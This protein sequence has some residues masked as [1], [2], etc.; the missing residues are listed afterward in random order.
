M[1]EAYLRRTIERTSELSLTGIDP[2]S[3]SESKAQL[4]LSSVYT[5]LLTLTPESHQRLN[6]GEKLGEET[7]R[8]SAL[9]QL[10]R[11]R[12]LVLL[13]DPGSGK[14]TF[15]NFVALCMAGE[16]LGHDEVNLALLTTPLPQKERSAPVPT[17]GSWPAFARAGDFARL[18]GSGIARSGGKSHCQT[19]LGLYC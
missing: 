2:K 8:L 1:R 11:H 9:E 19:S 13:G 10:N 6:R 7:R 18:R 17:L 3:A 14:S 15:V 16:S 4:S 5:A 12:R